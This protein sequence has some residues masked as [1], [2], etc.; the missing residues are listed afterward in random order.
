MTE[1]AVSMPH[2]PSDHGFGT[3]GKG[4][5]SAGRSSAPDNNTDPRSNSGRPIKVD[6][7]KQ[8][9]IYEQNAMLRF[10]E[11]RL[12]KKKEIKLSKENARKILRKIPIELLARDWLNDSKATVDIR[13]YMVDNVFP[14]LILGV[15]KLLTEVDSRQLAS[16]E[17]N[18]GYNPNFNPVNY[19]AQ[20][21]MRNNPRYSNFSEASPYVRGL[22][23]I[24]EELKAEL[25]DME[26]NR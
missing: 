17:I 4:S 21:L 26:D 10:S 3:P 5:H 24:A 23:Q 6:N 25:F 16:D 2:N 15:E 8:K 14:T 13:A 22:R 20:Y 1:V 11:V 12:F 9:K 19:L 18:G 7:K